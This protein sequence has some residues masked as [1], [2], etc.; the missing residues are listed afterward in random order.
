MEEEEGEA[1]QEEEEQPRGMEMKDIFA[2]KMRQ[3]VRRQARQTKAS[4]LKI[5]NTV[6]LATEIEAIKQQERTLMTKVEH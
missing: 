3:T 1:E 2:E 4:D 5:F 6:Q